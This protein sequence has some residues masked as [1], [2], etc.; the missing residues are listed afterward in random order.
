MGV[1]H[2]FR[3]LAEQALRG[4]AVKEVGAKT[5]D[6]A[7]AWPPPCD[8]AGSAPGEETIVSWWYNHGVISARGFHELVEA[9]AA[10][11]ACFDR[12]KRVHG[13]GEHLGADRAQR[14]SFAEPLHDGR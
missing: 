1:Q 7:T 12:G 2:I 6:F 3:Q 8:S 4:L 10:P 14:T 5:S 13:V 9:F 11:P